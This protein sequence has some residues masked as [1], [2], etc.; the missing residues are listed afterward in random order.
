M[1]LGLKVSVLRVPGLGL[2]L[3]RFD[4]E[5][6]GFKGHRRFNDL[7]ASRVVA[8]VFAGAC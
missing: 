5:A 8:G 6:W 2:G 7:L 1:G 4:V 3:G